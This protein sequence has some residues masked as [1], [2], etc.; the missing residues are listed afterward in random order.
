LRGFGFFGKFQQIYAT[1]FAFILGDPNLLSLEFS[2]RPVD[3]PDPK[4]FVVLLESYKTY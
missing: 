4:E 1:F 2:A 3:D